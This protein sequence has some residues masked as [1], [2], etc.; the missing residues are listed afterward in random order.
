M[1]PTGRSHQAQPMPHRTILVQGLQLLDSK[2]PKEPQRATPAA[3]DEVEDDAT[4]SN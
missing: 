3:G 1:Y 2:P 4:R